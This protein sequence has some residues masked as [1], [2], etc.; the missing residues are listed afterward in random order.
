MSAGTFTCSRCLYSSE[1]LG[2]SLI[3][4]P[5]CGLAEEAILDRN[6]TTEL[7]VG[8]YAVQ[9]GSRLGFGDISNLYRCNV[10]GLGGA[11]VFKVVRSHFA[12]AHLA[13]ESETLERILDGDDGRF[14]PFLPQP[15]ATT[16][17]IQSDTEPSRFAALLRYHEEIDRPDELYSLQEVRAAY[18]DGIEPRDMAWMWRRILTILGFVHQRGYA[19][20]LVTPDHILIE[21][22]THKLVLIS[23]CGAVALGC[24]PLLVPARWRDWVDPLKRVSQ[25]TDLAAAGRSMAYLLNSTADASISRHLQRAGIVSDAWKLLE[26]FDRL[27]EVLWGPRQFRTFA[28]PGR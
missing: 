21:P 22:R 26:D 1:R 15:L 8:R 14:R 3:F 9:V 18:P 4:C 6:Q 7:T 2:R 23:W 11:A 13:R 27:I 10:S 12:N 24:P 5:R 25:G 16:Q 28:M 17:L 20:A 19:H